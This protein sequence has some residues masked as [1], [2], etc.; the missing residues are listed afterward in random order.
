MRVD[1]GRHERVAML[2][3][4]QATCE[5]ALQFFDARGEGESEVVS[6]LTRI[7]EHARRELDALAE[8]QLL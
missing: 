6:D 7:I 1:D 5:K 4:L 8:D 2:V 3:M